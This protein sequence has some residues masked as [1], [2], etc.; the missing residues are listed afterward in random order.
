[1]NKILILSL[2]L[3]VSIAYTGCKKST[4]ETSETSAESSTAP[5][6]PNC[7]SKAGYHPHETIPSLKICNTCEVGY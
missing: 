1:M 6:C 2:V 5:E 3:M 4:S 7:G